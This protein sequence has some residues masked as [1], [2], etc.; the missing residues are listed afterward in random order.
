MNIIQTRRF[1]SPK[2][3]SYLI[4]RAHLKPP[5]L[6]VLHST[7]FLGIPAFFLIANLVMDILIV[8]YLQ[9]LLGYVPMQDLK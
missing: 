4:F 9:Y 5:K 8:T 7:E 1:C 2:S 3:P 6:V